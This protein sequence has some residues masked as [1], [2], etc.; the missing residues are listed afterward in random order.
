MASS[1]PS[2]N[3]GSDP[4]RPKM[5]PDDLPFNDTR[6]GW[7]WSDHCRNE[8]RAGKYGWAMA[9]C[10]RGLDLPGLDP[11]AKASLLYNEG[12]AFEGGGDKDAAKGL[13]ER[14]LAM[15]A[16]T[17][18]GRFEVSAALSRVGDIAPAPPDSTS[19]ACGATRCRAGQTCCSEVACVEGTLPQAVNCPLAEQRACDPK[20]NEPCGSQHCRATR[21]SATGTVWT[22]EP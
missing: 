8:V 1:S 15:R 7:G 6:H 12:L 22:C 17:D 19:Y 5:S 21:W 18:P 2:A 13:Y 16:P 4:H 11:K 14:S 9:A 20:T 10:Q 3:D